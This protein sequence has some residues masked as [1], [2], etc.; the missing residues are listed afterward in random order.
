MRRLIDSRTVGKFANEY[1]ERAQAPNTNGP[2]DVFRCG[3]LSLLQKT[4]H[5]RG[6]SNKLFSTLLEWALAR[7]R[8]Y[9]MF[10]LNQIT[11]LRYHY[12]ILD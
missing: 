5:Y 6:G 2:R 8:V 9:C 10:G 3:P 4:L 12:Q 7:T 11:F 1:S